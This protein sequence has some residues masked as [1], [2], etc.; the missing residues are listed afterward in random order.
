MPEAEEATADKVKR[1]W[2]RKST[3]LEA[4]A[5]AEEPELEPNAKIVQTS[6]ALALLRALRAWYGWSVFLAMF[7]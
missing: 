5:A 4:E 3:I 1:G 6:K 2:K 7:Y